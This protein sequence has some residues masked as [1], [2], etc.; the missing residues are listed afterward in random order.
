LLL[1]CATTGSNSENWPPFPYPAD[2]A[3]MAGTDMASA[4]AASVKTMIGRSPICLACNIV[5]SLHRPFD[6][7]GSADEWAGKPGDQ[8]DEI[9]LAVRAGLFEQAA[10]MRLDRAFGDTKDFG[11]LRNATHL[12]DAEKDTQLG[13]RQLVDPGDELGRT[14]RLHLRLANEQDGHGGA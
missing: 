8:P 3:A 4:Q 10:D 9:G 1:C 6:D 5:S 13:R 7:S 2:D 11:D 12:D 14:G